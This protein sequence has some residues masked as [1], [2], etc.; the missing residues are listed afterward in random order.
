MVHNILKV[1]FHNRYKME[2]CLYDDKED[3]IEFANE[4]NEQTFFKANFNSTCQHVF[5]T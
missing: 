3:H 1:L 4:K 2:Y 5:L